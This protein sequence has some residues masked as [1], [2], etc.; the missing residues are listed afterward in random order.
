MFGGLLA[1]VAGLKSRIIRRLLARDIQQQIRQLLLEDPRI[2]AKFY[3][4]KQHHPSYLLTQARPEERDTRFDFPIPPRDLQEASGLRTPEAWLAFG[5]SR[6][7][8]MKELLAAS[9]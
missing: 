9:G 4:Y 5:Q 6:V 7:D 1:R 8:R 3:P 2:A